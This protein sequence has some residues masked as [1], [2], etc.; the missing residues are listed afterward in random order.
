GAS[1]VGLSAIQIAKALGAGKITATCS[2]AGAELVKQVG[3][4]ETIDYK[5]VDFRTGDARYD[6]VFDCV[7]TAPYDTC[8]QVLRG[9]RVHLTVQPRVKTFLRSFANPLFGTKVF[10]LITTGDGA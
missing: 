7:G 6:V 4:D 10:G 8:Q 2:S 9:R 3:A 5:T 1:S